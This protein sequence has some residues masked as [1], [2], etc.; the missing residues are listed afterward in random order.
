ME[1]STIGHGHFLDANIWEVFHLNLPE[2]EEVTDFLLGG[3]GANALDVD[4]GRHACRFFFLKVCLIV[5]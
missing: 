1:K 2:A 5:G 4:G 3:L